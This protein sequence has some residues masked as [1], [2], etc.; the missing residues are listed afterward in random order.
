LHADLRVDPLL[1]RRVLRPWQRA[2]NE[3]ASEPRT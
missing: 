3:T 1:L 2:Y